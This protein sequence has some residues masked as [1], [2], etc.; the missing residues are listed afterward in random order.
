MKKEQNNAL[1]E[2]RGDPKIITSKADKGGVVV[3]S[4]GLKKKKFKFLSLF[5]VYNQ[6]FTINPTD[7]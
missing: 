2:S 5:I 1:N 3:G 4:Q 6:L 7:L